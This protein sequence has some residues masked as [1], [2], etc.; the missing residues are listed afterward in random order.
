[1][2]IV[3]YLWL[4]LIFENHC[5]MFPHFLVDCPYLVMFATSIK[6]Q[7]D[8]ASAN[9]KDQLSLYARQREFQHMMHERSAENRRALLE[10]QILN[11]QELRDQGLKWQIVQLQQEYK[12]RRKDIE[13][14]HILSHWPLNTQIDTYLSEFDSL[15]DNH[16]IPLRVMVAMTDV[17]TPNKTNI[18]I[19]YSNLC[20]SLVSQVGGNTNYLQIDFSPWRTKCINPYSD[21]MVI[22]Y[23][24]EGLPTLLIFP[25]RTKGSIRLDYSVWGINNGRNM[26]SYNN[27]CTFSAD[28][29]LELVNK[30]IISHIMCV[31]DTYSR[32]QYGK[33]IKFKDDVLSLTN[34]LGGLCNLP[35]L[36]KELEHVCETLNI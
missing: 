7:Q 14:E 23:I 11:Q 21:A 26:M 25:Y 12:N 28:T 16:A 1:M 10:Q 20:Q 5:K 6:N 15:G 2:R 32:L 24:L 18:P 34:E 30:A 22:H 9:R 13:F 36:Y 17:T 29:N 31:S 35:S 3:W 19:D 4:C 27:L 33:S 8:I